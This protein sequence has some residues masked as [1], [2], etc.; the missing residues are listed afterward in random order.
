MNKTIFKQ[1]F[2]FNTLNDKQIKKKKNIVMCISLNLSAIFFFSANL[3]VFDRYNRCKLTDEHK[4]S[5]LKRQRKCI[6]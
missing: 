1:K 5:E 3:Q 2:N 4:H 6:T